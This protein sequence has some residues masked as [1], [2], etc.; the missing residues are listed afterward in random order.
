MPRYDYECGGCLYEFE[1]FARYEGRDS[2]L[3]PRCRITAKRV[4]RTAPGIAFKGMGW[5]R[6]E[7]GWKSMMAEKRESDRNIRA[8]MDEQK[9]KNFEKALNEA[10]PWTDQDHADYE[11]VKRKMARENPDGNTRVTVV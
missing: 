5:T 11:A 7:S 6:N 8:Y 2:V 9:D 4:W 10:K 1:A 3:C